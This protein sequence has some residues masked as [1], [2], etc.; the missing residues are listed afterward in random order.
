[1]RFKQILVSNFYYEYQKDEQGNV[2]YF[3]PEDSKPIYDTEN[4]VY[5]YDDNGNR[6]LDS[7]GK[8]MCFDTEGNILYDKEKGYPA[9]TLD[10]K[11]EAIKHYYTDEQMND[12]IAKMQN[13][14][15]EVGAK[16]YSAFEAHMPEWELFESPDEY[17]ADGVHFSEELGVPYIS[18]AVIKKLCEV[19]KIEVSKIKNIESVTTEKQD[20]SVF[21]R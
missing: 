13:L 10:D 17:Y 15:C 1:M 16:N 5:L 20:A 3:D 14:L 11:G 21:G 2:I 4:G 19:G 18:Q 6:L 12:R 8:T 7:Y 9:A